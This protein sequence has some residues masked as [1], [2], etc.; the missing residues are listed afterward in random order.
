MI[1]TDIIRP[2]FLE[3][4]AD[5]AKGMATGNLNPRDAYCYWDIHYRA[6]ELLEI[7]KENAVAEKDAPSSKG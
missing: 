1:Q 4:L 2:R 5:A 7:A 3:Q 6:I